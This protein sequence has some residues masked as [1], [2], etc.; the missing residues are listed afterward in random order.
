VQLR[1]GKEHDFSAKGV[2]G[3]TA[4]LILP[5][6][7]G[8]DADDRFIGDCWPSR[9]FS[10]PLCFNFRNLPEHRFYNRAQL[11]EKQ[12]AILLTKLDQQSDNIKTI[13]QAIIER[14]LTTVTHIA[15][16]TALLRAP[17]EQKTALQEA[18][19]VLALDR[20]DT[21]STSSQ[22]EEQIS[23]HGLPFLRDPFTKT[24][25]ENEYVSTLII[26]FIYVGCGNNYAQFAL[27]FEKHYDATN[28]FIRE[29]LEFLDRSNDGYYRIRG[30]LKQMETTKPEVIQRNPLYQQAIAS[31]RRLS[32]FIRN[33]AQAIAEKQRLM[34]EV[35]T[36]S[37]P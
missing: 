29:T 24:D 4:R 30:I 28:P 10:R 8:S 16:N 12:S 37:T 5:S 2:N 23:G 6:R 9:D 14:L 21:P 13:N 25:L 1:R 19:K 3:Y 33:A 26:T 34:L 7:G 22:G 31:D 15:E 11:A 17:Q 27:P 35:E 32:P 20:T 36:A 18:I